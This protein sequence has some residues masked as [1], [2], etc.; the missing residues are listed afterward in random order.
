MERIILACG[1]SGVNSVEDLS[2]ADLGYADEVYEH[3]LGEDK[4]TFIEGVKNPKSC[5]I[6]IKGP[7]EHTIAMIKEAI[8]DGLRAVKNVF[9]DKSVIPGAGSFEIAAYVNLQ[10]FKDTVKGKAKMGV[11]A[12]AESLLIIPKTIAE[13]CGYDV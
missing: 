6:L 1:G 7:N 9:D 3:T 8:R 10:K 12:F 4:Y 13:N 11:E 5:T 2:E